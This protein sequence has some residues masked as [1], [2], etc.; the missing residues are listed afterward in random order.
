MEERRATYREQQG[1]EAIKASMAWRGHDYVGA[2]LI[3]LS[4][5]GA[6]VALTI[7]ARRAP[8][9]PIGTSVYLRF[10][11]PGIDPIS[12]I[13]ALIRNERDSDDSRLFGVEIADWPTLS[14]NLPPRLFSAFNRR[15]HYRR[16]FHRTDRHLGH[17]PR[18]IGRG[19]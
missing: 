5:R 4:A 1:L 2:S 17:Q 14:D 15:R 3:D 16:Q 8:T 6:A 7:P 13:L 19:E 18:P 11:I 9:L 10:E 12:N